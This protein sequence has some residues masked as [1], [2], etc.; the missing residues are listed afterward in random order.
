[1]ARGSE[2][3]VV[4]AGVAGAAT[5]LYLARAG[6]R[7]T[8]LEAERPAFGAS[9]RNPGFLFLLGK[10]AGLPL[11]VAEAGRVFQAGL[12]AEIGG[13]AFRP[14]GLLAF[15]RDERALAPLGAF[16]RQ[17]REEGLSV[18]LL[19]R[20]E[21]LR[22]VPALAPDVVGGL[23]SEREAQQDTG[24]LVGRLVDAAAAAGARFE[25]AKAEA[26]LVAGGRCGGL[27]L[28]GG[29]QRG[30]DLVVLANG[31]DGRRLLAPLGLELPL[32]PV[33]YQA[34]E[35]APAPFRLGALLAGPSLFGHLPLLTQQPGYDPA[36]FA[37]PWIGLPAGMSYTHQI[38][39]RPDGR[40]LF[41]CAAESGQRDAVATVAGQ[42]PAL[43]SLARDLPAAGALGVERS[44]AGIVA[45][46]PDYLPVIDPAPGIDGLAL[47]LGHAF[48]NL[49]GAL[50]GQMLAAALSGGR[51]PFA[52]EAFAL[53][54][55][56]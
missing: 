56:G 21:V 53:S 34:A 45:Q 7:V 46:A 37:D 47:N 39:Q 28:A 5:A 3:L 44:W 52:L 12:A 49:A 18:A 16:A 6:A 22:R 38:A 40:L 17:R 14:C 1:M 23:F 19:D 55:F 50:S 48:G 27:R 8:L 25:T 20:S 31:L 33:R 15:V 24:L 35:S 29:E 51:P 41:G 13:F 32:T 42:A 30:A 43:A 11:S 36:A 9:G 26:L 54:R 10:R 2:A 4:G